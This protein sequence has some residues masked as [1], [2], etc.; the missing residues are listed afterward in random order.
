[1]KLDVQREKWEEG[2]LSTSISGKEKKKQKRKS[3]REGG[4]INTL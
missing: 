4:K 1:M 3:E 2:V